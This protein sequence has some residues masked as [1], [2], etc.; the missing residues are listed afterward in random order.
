MCIHEV[1]VPFNSSISFCFLMLHRYDRDPM[2]QFEKGAMN[3]GNISAKSTSTHAEEEEKEPVGGSRVTVIGDAAHPMS[4]FKGQGANQALADGPLLAQ[5]LMY[6]ASKG[7]GATSRRANTNSGSS[8][9]G[10]TALGTSGVVQD[11]LPAKRALDNESALSCNAFLMNQTT[12]FTRLRCFEREMCDRTTPKVLASRQAAEHLHSAQVLEDIFG[13]AGIKIYDSGRNSEILSALR[14][15]GVGAA[16][17]P[18]L[19]QAMKIALEKF[20]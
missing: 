8:A 9:K 16:L 15:A 17:G 19:D 4:M 13:I 11:L 5:W 14:E 20:V 1:I 10:S 12:V 6:G 3:N 2:P 18:E 7:K